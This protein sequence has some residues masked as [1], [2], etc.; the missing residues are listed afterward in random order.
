MRDLILESLK[1]AIAQYPEIIPLLNGHAAKIVEDGI[2]WHQ[3]FKPYEGED[4]GRI[5]EEDWV[6]T[7]ADIDA[8]V[9]EWDRLMPEYAGMLNAE[10]ADA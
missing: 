2:E 7:Q 5:S 8:A 4:Y 3:N 1:Q 6:I 10:V 9:A